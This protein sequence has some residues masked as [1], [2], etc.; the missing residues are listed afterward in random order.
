MNPVCIIFFKEVRD[1]IRDRRSLLS[2]L[3]YPLLGPLVFAVLLHVL[4]GILAHGG[5][6]AQARFSVPL[7][8][9]GAEEAPEVISFLSENGLKIQ[10]ASEAAIDAVK[11]G[12]W[13]AVLVIPKGYADSV[14]NRRPVRFKLVSDASRI[15]GEL[16]VGKV[17]D[18][19]H[20]YGRVVAARH[21]RQSGLEPSL[22]EPLL[23]DNQVVVPRGSVFDLFLFLVPPF[24]MFTL[25]IG[26]VYLAIDTVSGERE[27][28]SL[29]P[30]MANP[31]PRWQFMLG[32]FLAA[33]LFTGLSLLIQLGAFAAVFG[34]LGE[35]LFTTGR[36]F[37][38]GVILAL[39]LTCLPLMA[40]T[41]AIQIIIA[42]LT[43][44]FKEAQTWLGLL[45][46]V[47]AI[48]GLM[49]VFTPVQGHWWMMLFPLFSQT[50]TMGQVVRGEMIPWWHL[51]LSA[52]F[53]L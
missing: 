46:L 17:A 44:S 52:V 33:Y 22:A 24:V 48:P 27:R 39:L 25:F 35:G 16:L 34:T 36:E 13:P 1:N 28:G 47:P 49:M 20:A 19:L 26:G 6:T 7:P 41:V 38:P 50:V 51:G 23:V 8:V 5:G 32:K 30:L 45:P 10:P 29:E 15:T 53:T 21:L 3:I 42:A 18:L 40:V 37:G 9:V 2:A 31:V 4:S 43:R 11:R 14:A 12:D